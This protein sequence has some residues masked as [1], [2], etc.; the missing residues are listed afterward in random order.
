MTYNTKRKAG[1]KTRNYNGKLERTVPSWKNTKDRI[2]GNVLGL[3]WYSSTTLAYLTSPSGRTKRSTMGKLPSSYTT[4]HKN[5][6]KKVKSPVQAGRSATA[7]H[8]IEVFLVM[9][10][11]C[12]GRRTFMPVYRLQHG[13]TGLETR[14][15]AVSAIHRR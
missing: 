15:T 4:K 2:M 12:W 9:L 1:N 14:K 11:R 13:H 6:I 3:V 8:L 5:S 10:R 7:Q